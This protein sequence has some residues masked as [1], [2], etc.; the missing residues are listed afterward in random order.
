VI[1]AYIDET[2]HPTQ[3]T[4]VFAFAGFMARVGDWKNFEHQ[5]RSACPDDLFPFHM[6]NFVRTRLPET[7]RREILGGLISCITQNNLV[8]FATIVTLSE[9]HSLGVSDRKRVGN[10][11]YVALAHLMSQVGVA[12]LGAVDSSTGPF[13]SMPRVSVIFAKSEFSGRALDWWWESKTSGLGR[14]LAALVSGMLI[15]KIAVGRPEEEIPL[16]AADL[17]AYELGHHHR[18]IRP[19][20]RAARW[21]FDQ[22]N[23]LP[24]V[25]G[26]AAPSHCA[27]TNDLLLA[28]EYAAFF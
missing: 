8:P 21:P 6:M 14:P 2:G 25:L 19:Q 9:Y 16:Q 18:S 10:L 17:W 13:P 20:K 26:V 22:I 11:Y 5:W 24:A 12:V 15:E 23:Q 1:A 28:S 3:R 27:L 7:R 4:G